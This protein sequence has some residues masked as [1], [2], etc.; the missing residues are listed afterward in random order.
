[1]EIISELENRPRGFYTGTMGYI[2]RDGSADLSILIRTM[3]VIGRDL[4][5][6]TGSGIVAD[7]DP[8]QELDET[9][10]KAKGLL[11][12]LEQNGV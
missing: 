1:M 8:V 12:A 6:A 11:L 5:F 4:S 3:T 2:N 9:H 10:A 7:S